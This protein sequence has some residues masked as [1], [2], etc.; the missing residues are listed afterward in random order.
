MIYCMSDIHG[1]VDRYHKMLEFIEFSDKDTL[2][3]IGD[4]IDRYPGGIDL[5]KEI[6]NEPNIKFI[7]GNHEHMMIDNLGPVG[8]YYHKYTWLNNGGDVT[9]FE[10]LNMTNKEDQRV[11]LKYLM[12]AP[13]HIDITVNKKKYHL[14]HGF[15]DDN[16]IGRVWNRPS[17]YFPFG[18]D[19][20]A[21][22]IIGH[23][24]T[25]CLKTFDNE[26]EIYHGKGFIDIDCGCGHDVKGKRLACL[27]LDDLKEFY[28]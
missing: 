21:V 13:D 16:I 19:N 4:V 10:W 6:I 26:V 25:Y 3:I 11:I 12:D 8:I 18:W 24:P 17:P 20:N 7:L 23:T 2:Y 1:E 15:P 28:I 27:R 5:L 22:A 14:V 9:Y